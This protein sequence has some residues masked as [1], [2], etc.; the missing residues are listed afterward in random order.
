M[1]SDW[2]PSW[3]GLQAGAA[4]FTPLHISTPAL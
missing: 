3:F 2:T 4:D 1:S